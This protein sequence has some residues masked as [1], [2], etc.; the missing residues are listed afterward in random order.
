[1]IHRRYPIATLWMMPLGVAMV[2]TT[3]A[4]QALVPDF[5]APATAT[6]ERRESV[7]SYPVPVGPWAAGSIP[8]QVAEG[9]VSQTAWRLDAPGSSTLELL[10]PLRAQ[11]AAAGFTTLFE[12]ETTACGGFD[13]RYGTVNLPE[14]DMHIDLGDFRFLS[15]ERQGAKGPEHLSLMVSRSADRGY[16]QLTL[17]GPEAMAPPTLA[18][19]TKAPD[20]AADAPALPPATPL[21]AA[22]D[23]GQ[24]VALDDLAFA[25]GSDVLVDAD[26]GSLADLAAWLATDPARRIT[27]V[28]HTDSSGDAAANLA[29]SQSR[30]E[31]VLQALV[32]RFGI[33][34]DRLTAT[35]KGADVPRA[36]NATPEG[37]AQNR[38][39]EVEPTPTL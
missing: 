31:A 9:V 2:L 22:L 17:V 37:R 8:T 32:T 27:L 7:A 10:Q 1:M 21:A 33:A 29:L 4:A 34:A 26:Y 20:P 11:I 19:S 24:A 23:A 13:F 15:A 36:D 25:S 28:G 14:P 39:V 3:G 18:L 38:R 5:A 12:C 35:G 16:V 30:A 6:G